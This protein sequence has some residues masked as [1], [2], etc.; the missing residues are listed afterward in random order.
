[1]PVQ[2]K[3]KTVAYVDFYEYTA[4]PVKTT[5]K[6]ENPFRWQL[7][8]G[9]LLYNDGHKP[10]TDAAIEQLPLADRRH[11]Y[12]RA[13][14]DPTSRHWFQVFSDNEPGAGALSDPNRITA[15]EFFERFSASPH[16]AWRRQVDTSLR[17]YARRLAELK[18][19]RLREDQLLKALD[20]VKPADAVKAKRG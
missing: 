5:K 11:L 6:G 4:Y 9:R 8:R 13:R 1:M 17:Q 14:K 16:A 2:P 18:A 3:I 7:L 19:D 20:K 15:K 10:F 12:K